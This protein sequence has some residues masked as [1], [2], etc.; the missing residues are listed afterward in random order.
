[1]RLSA[2]RLTSV[3]AFLASV[4]LTS[5]LVAFVR[6]SAVRL[7]SGV[8]AFL[9]SIR[10]TSRLV[11]FV[12][13][14]AVRL[15]SGLLAFFASVR[16]AFGWPSSV[17]PASAVEL[18][19]VRLLSGLL[20]S[21]LLSGLLVC[22]LLTT[23]RQLAI[24]VTP[25]APSGRELAPSFV[26]ASADLLAPRRAIFLAKSPQATALGLARLARLARFADLA[27]LACLACLACLAS[28]ACLACLAC[29]VTLALLGRA[30]AKLQIATMDEHAAIPH[31]MFLVAMAVFLAVFHSHVLVAT[32]PPARRR[33]AHAIEPSA[34]PLVAF[35]VP[36]PR[37]VI[38][39]PCGVLRTTCGV[40]RTPRGAL[41]YLFL[42]CLFLARSES[43]LVPPIV[44]LLPTTAFI[45]P[46]SDIA[47]VANPHDRSPDG[48]GPA[49]P[50]PSGLRT[51]VP[52]D[53]R[54]TKALAAHAWCTP[55]AIT[56]RHAA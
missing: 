7:T 31:A 51:R 17:R 24:L 50:D 49:L 27:S 10:L 14:S 4:R 56:G 33:V 53:V 40:L 2:V 9:A 30:S 12:R 25:V 54:A 32:T 48:R 16:L 41:A 20:V 8:V 42:A 13:R 1:V 36:T 35:A 44:R 39:T 6:L 3:F 23:E 29:S 38:R 26:E 5:G 52:C 11:A 22:V 45:T 55:V 19:S 34:I 47:I 15:T 18:A 46:C 28:L 43:I 37:G 21:A